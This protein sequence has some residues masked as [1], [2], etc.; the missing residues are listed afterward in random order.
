MIT[1]YRV[2]KKLNK[3]KKENFGPVRQK[4]PVSWFGFPHYPHY[5]SNF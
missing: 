5:L 3:K 1:I 4:V 2:R